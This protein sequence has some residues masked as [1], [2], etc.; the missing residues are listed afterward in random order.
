MTEP[1]SS[2]VWE[3][4]QEPPFLVHDT[5]HVWRAQL[6]MPEERLNTLRP[7]LSED[8][9]ERAGR[10]HFPE[11][12]T[13]FM[14]ARGILRTLLGGYT[15]LPPADIRFAYAAR[16]K[17]FLAESHAMSGVTFNISHSADMALFAFAR[18]RRL[19][20]D[21]ERIRPDVE[22][23][24]LARR[25]FSPRESETLARLPQRVRSQAFHACWTRKEAYIKAHGEGLFMALDRFDVG[26]AP[27]E[28][29]ELLRTLD[30]PEEISLWQLVNLEPGPGFAGALAV[31]CPAAAVS[32]YN[33]F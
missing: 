2:P 23:L 16:G 22:V 33:W 10:F 21:I 18:E 25:F 11:H 27:D 28:P 14:A 13:R 32:R 24:K 17:P 12:R 4:P 30:E 8:E 5:A 19:G 29:C 26:F 20:V 6:D 7:L 3:I 15:G 9:Q 1:Q 31:E